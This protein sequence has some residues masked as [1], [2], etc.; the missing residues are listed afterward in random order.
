MDHKI[1]KAEKT[2]TSSA[3]WA[4]SAFIG[5]CTHQYFLRIRIYPSQV[6]VD[7]TKIY[8][9]QSHKIYLSQLK[10]IWI[11]QSMLSSHDRTRNRKHICKVL[12]YLEI[13]NNKIL[14]KPKVK[15]TSQGNTKTF[16]VNWRWKD[17]ISKFVGRSWSSA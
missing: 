5:H 2:W 12:K 14:S 9:F 8:C 3:P 1:N 4:S 6:H 10:R 7:I 13:S 16:Q 17:N 11:I 15:E